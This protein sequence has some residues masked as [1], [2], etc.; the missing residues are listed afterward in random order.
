MSKKCRSLRH[1]KTKQEA[2]SLPI[3]YEDYEIKYRAKRNYKNLPNAYDDIFIAEE[4]SW[5]YKS[6]KDKQ[7]NV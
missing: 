1:P 5:K 4:K 7:Y 3:D 2:N 6:K